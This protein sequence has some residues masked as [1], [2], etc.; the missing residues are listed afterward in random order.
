[1]KNI[2]FL[3]LLPLAALIFSSCEKELD[4]QP[5]D[6]FT[7]E[8]AFQ[9]LSH[10]QLGTNAAYGRYGAYLNDIYVSALLSD[11]AKLGKDNSGQG[12][13]TYRFQFSSDGT[14][15]GDVTAA[16]GSYYS[17]IDQCNRVLAAFST[18]TVK[19]SEEARKSVLRG[20][21]LALRGLGHFGLLQAYCA[22]YNPSDVLG[23]PVM[24]VSDPSG[25]PARNTQGEVMAAI[26]SD[27]Y[28]ARE[29]LTRQPFF[30]TVMNRD[31]VNAYL[32]RIFLYQGEY[33]SAFSYA[34]EVISS[35][36]KTIADNFEFPGIWTDANDKETL[37]RIRYITSTA[38][39][40]LWTTTGGNIYIAPSDK[41]TNSYNQ[42]DIRLTTFI[43]YDADGDRYVNKYFESG[44]GGRV[45]DMKACRISEMYLIRAEASAR[46]SSPDV[47]GGANDLNQLRTARISGYLPQTFSTA[48]DLVNAV[49]QERYKELCF[50]GF[51]FWDLK[52]NNL[53]VERLSTDAS[54][55]WQTLPAGDYRFVLPIPRD[56]LN[57]NPN[58]VQN[59]GY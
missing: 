51:R 11:E 59:P 46:K 55:A 31:N 45:V 8:N 52:R 7:Q 39:G 4:L 34:N 30:D 14:T 29:L 25:K 15:G 32:A 3:I 38:V 18:V 48:Q 27:L 56:E 26:K 24:L 57:V 19:P 50:E 10:L 42:N 13:L 40:G 28:T 17:L 54:A 35:N 1:M 21:L 33:D 5:T 47:S 43:G 44:R 53:N 36:V 37:F 12:A 2:K 58:M 23:V 22:N 16:F 49:L 9:N 20:Q 6:L 41:L